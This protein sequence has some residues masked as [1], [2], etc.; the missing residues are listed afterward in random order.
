MK[1]SLKLEDRILK[2]DRQS[3][4]QKKVTKIQTIINKILRRKLTIEQHESH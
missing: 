4:Y 3:N 2:K 1:K